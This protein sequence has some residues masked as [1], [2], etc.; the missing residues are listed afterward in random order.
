HERPLGFFEV[1]ADPA[2][3]DL[4]TTEDVSLTAP[5]GA[6]W[7]DKDPTALWYAS[8]IGDRWILGNG[9]DANLVFKNG[10]LSLWGPQSEPVYV[11]DRARVAFPPCTCFRLH[12]NRSIF[13]TGNVSQPMR[14]W[15]SDPPNSQFTLFEGIY[16]LQTSFVDVHAMKGATRITALSVYQ[17]YVTVHTDR[18][19]VNL[20]GVDS[21][22]D[23]FKCN[24]SASAANASAMNP[25]CVGDVEGDASYYFGRDLELYFDQAVRSGPY[26]KRGARDQEIATTQGAEFWNR[27]MARDVG[28]YGYHTLYD[29]QTRLMWIFARSIFNARTMCWVFNERTRTCCGPLHYPDAIVSTA[30]AGLLIPSTRRAGVGLMSIGSTFTVS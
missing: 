14:V 11:Y 10:A 21:V 8:Q 15:I 27:D 3:S 5:A 26:E 7:R 1:V 20:Y 16:S 30:L 22:S 9:I 6:V 13:A 28:E 17:Q 24:Q 12:V 4:D 23:G 2:E 18:A 29:R 25:A 19:P